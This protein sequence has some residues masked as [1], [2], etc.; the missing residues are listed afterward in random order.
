MKSSCKSSSRSELK[1]EHTGVFRFLYQA[2]LKVGVRTLV[3]NGGAREA[4]WRPFG[5]LGGGGCSCK[6]VW[7]SETWDCLKKLTGKSS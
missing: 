5:G 1:T 3:L 6:S 2:L 4:V 7:V